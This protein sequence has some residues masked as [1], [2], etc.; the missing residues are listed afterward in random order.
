MNTRCCPMLALAVGLC[1]VFP[2]TGAP[3]STQASFPEPSALPFQA[4]L[5]DPLVMLDGRRVTSRDQWVKER[6]PE[7]LALF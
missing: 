7:L 1:G 2:A 3:P 6:R 4:A 5:P